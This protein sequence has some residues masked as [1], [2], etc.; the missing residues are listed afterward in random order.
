MLVPMDIPVRPERGRRVGFDPVAAIARLLDELVEVEEAAEVVIVY[1]RP[2]SAA[3]R[4]EDS[5]WFEFLARVEEQAEAR[6]RSVVFVGGRR[7]RVI[8]A[9]GVEG[10]AA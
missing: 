2:G 9:R 10:S 4:P 8:H 5:A 6:I 3:L 7:F 1:E